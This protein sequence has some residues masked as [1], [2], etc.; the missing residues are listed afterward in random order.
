[1][2]DELKS[3]GLDRKN[4][5]KISFT[6]K[7]LLGV[8]GGVLAG[9]CAV[10]T[11]FVSPALRKVCLPYVPATNRQVQNVMQLLKDKPG[12]VVDLGSGDGRIVSHELFYSI[13]QKL[14]S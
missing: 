1:M 7:V 2:M 10:S 11:P 13:I 8:T 5:R 3:L 6:G 9:I 4:E 12:H 14:I